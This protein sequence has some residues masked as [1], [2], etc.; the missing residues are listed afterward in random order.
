MSVIIEY[1]VARNWSQMHLNFV[2]TVATHYNLI[3]ALGACRVSGVSG[4][5]LMIWLK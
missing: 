4:N 3:T 5:H 1:T 2:Q